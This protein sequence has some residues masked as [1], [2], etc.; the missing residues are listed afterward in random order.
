M[1]RVKRLRA[2]EVTSLALIGVVISLSLLPTPLLVPHAGAQSPVSL[3][4]FYVEDCPRCREITVLIEGLAGTYPELEVHKLEISSNTTNRELFNA[5]IMV[6]NPPVVDIPAAFIGNTSVIGY[7]LTKERLETEIAFCVRNKCPDPLSRVTGKE[8]HNVQSPPLTMLIVT[9]LTE[10]IINLCG[11]AVFIILLASLLFL[12]SK[13]NVLS[14]G[15]AFIVSILATRLLIG[16]G[17]MEFYLLSGMNQV[18]RTIVILVIVVAGIINLLDFWR[19][20][21]TLAIPSSLKPTLRTLASYASLPGAVLLGFLVTLVGLPCTG[22]IYLVMLKMIAAMPSQASVYLILYNL[23]YALPLCVILALI[24]RGTSP[25]DIEEW[26]KGK[27]R[28]LKLIAGVVMLAW[29]TAMLFG[30][31]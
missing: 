31:V 16:F 29:G 10:G 24:Y 4:Y 27:R 30:F 25:E 19:G 12:N 7:E 14:L 20:T 9:G 21:A 28:Y 22:P 17:I 18:A 5:F 13:R 8:G 11:F 26:R 2:C 23:F 3:Y 1:Q 6:Y 15:L